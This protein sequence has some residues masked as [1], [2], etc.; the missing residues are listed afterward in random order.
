VLATTGQK[1][2]AASTLRSA[3]AVSRSSGKHAVYN[4]FDHGAL[5]LAAADDGRTLVQIFE[6]T[7]DVDTWMVSDG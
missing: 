1:D 2:E 6:T 3:L 5:T 7:R 4:A